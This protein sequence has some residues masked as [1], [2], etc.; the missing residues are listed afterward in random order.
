MDFG[1]F[2]GKALCF[3]GK[4]ALFIV[5]EVGKAIWNTCQE[6]NNK[7]DEYRGY[8]SR[9]LER[10]IASGTLAE[11]MAANAVMKEKG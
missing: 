2:A 9:T 1:E 3:T 11:K 6:A 8:S 4:A 5:K 7:R 10:K